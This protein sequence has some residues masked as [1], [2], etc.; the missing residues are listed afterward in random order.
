MT[1]ADYIRAMPKVELHIHLEGAVQPQTLFYL[2]QRHH[3]TLPVSNVSELAAWYSFRD[4]NHFLDIFTKICE[5]L[6]TPEDFTRITYECGQSMARQNIRYAEVTWTPYTHVYQFSDIPW[7][8]LLAAIDA[9]R[10][11]AQRDFGVDEIRIAFFVFSGG[12]CLF[13]AH[14]FTPS[15]TT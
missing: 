13:N 2:A 8:D 11:Q 6:R 4:F 14:Q 12:I 15:S 1:L 3:I 5:C 7:N 10:E 9:G